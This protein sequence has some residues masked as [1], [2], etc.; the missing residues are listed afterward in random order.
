GQIEMVIM[1]TRDIEQ[2]TKIKHD[3][4]E[5]QQ[6]S[7]LYYRDS[8]ITAEEYDCLNQLVSKSDAFVSRVETARQ[9]APT[10]ANVLLLGETGTGKTLMAKYIH[11]NSKMKD[12]PFFTINCAAIPEYLLES[13][14]FG[15][16]KGAFTGAIA[17]KKGIFDLAD[18]GTL[19]LDEIGEIPMHIQAKLLQ[20]IQE[21][22][23]LPVGGRSYHQV[24]ARILSSTNCNLAEAV[25][26]GKF[27]SDLYYRLNV[28]EIEMPP[29]REREGDISALAKFF[30]DRFN[31][32]YKTYHSLDPAGMELLEQYA[33]PGNIRQLQNFIER[34]VLMVKEERILPSHFPSSI[35]QDGIPVATLAIDRP[36][37]QVDSLANSLA[38]IEKKRILEAMA[39]YGS[40]RKVA[41]AL[42]IS[43]SKASRLIRKYR[44]TE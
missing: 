43:Q 19:F 1:N 12:G 22:C 16:K 35:H 26:K 40:S 4:G 39:R 34:L 25:K 33:W 37:E 6:L 11:Q 38:Q 5:C 29:L 28:I 27:R 20:A 32:Q 23:F 9:V 30:L 2:L 41:E 3:I 44:Q 31:E 7:D 42:D 13:E 17:D 10:N 8:G 15:H 18:Q 21:R 24:T 14:L 36:L